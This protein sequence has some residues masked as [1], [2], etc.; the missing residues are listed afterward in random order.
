MHF[1]YILHISVFLGYTSSICHLLHE[2]AIYQ[3][4]EL[5]L[6]YYSLW[7]RKYVHHRLLHRYIHY[8]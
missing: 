3:N 2:V 8:H 6:N 5:L 1:H 4:L 7:K